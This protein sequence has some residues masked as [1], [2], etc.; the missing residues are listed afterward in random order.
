MTLP[1]DRPFF[2]LLS[3]LLSFQFGFL[4]RFSQGSVGSGLRGGGG[5]LQAREVGVGVGVGVERGGVRVG[6][7][8]AFGHVEWGWT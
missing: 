1:W 7:S 6:G 2:P 3:L 4:G 5:G 8:G